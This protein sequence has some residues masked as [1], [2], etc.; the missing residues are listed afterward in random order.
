MEYRPI[1]H[2]DSNGIEYAQHPI[3]TTIWT[4]KTGEV[5]SSNEK[6]QNEDSGRFDCI[7]HKIPYKK[8]TLHKHKKGKYERFCY[9]VSFKHN[10]KQYYRPI[11]KLIYESWKGIVKNLFVV[12][13][14]D[15]NI[16][17]NNLDNFQETTNRNNVR[18]QKKRDDNISGFKGVSFKKDHNSYQSRIKYNNKQFHLGYFEDPIQAALAYD[19]AALKYFG[20]FALTNKMLGLI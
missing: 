3:F 5:W 7:D 14:K 18:K 11:H 10:N 6:F 12:D 1:T 4:T 17:N 19:E 9:H 8:F 16:E 15:N 2:I 13:H 20:E